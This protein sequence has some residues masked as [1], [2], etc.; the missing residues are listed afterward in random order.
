MK[1]K[2][3]LFFAIESYSSFMAYKEVTEK[4]DTK[5]ELF[6]TLKSK[7]DLESFKVSSAIITVDGDKKIISDLK[8]EGYYIIAHSELLTKEKVIKTVKHNANLLENMK[9]N[10]WDYVVKTIQ[11]FLPVE[12]D[13]IVLNKN[14][15]QIY[16]IKQITKLNQG[17]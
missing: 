9:N 15:N 14:F 2:Q 17:R 8:H 1:I 10:G 6:D 16:P 7:K 5:K 11:G 12:K 3:K 4:F 13:T